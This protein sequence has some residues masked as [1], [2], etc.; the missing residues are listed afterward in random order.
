MRKR[1]GRVQQV[2]AM[3][4]LETPPLR[5]PSQVAKNLA[6]AHMCLLPPPPGRVQKPFITFHNHCDH[7]SST[8]T[9]H[10]SK[11][12]VREPHTAMSTAIHQEN[13]NPS[14]T[15]RCALTSGLGEVWLTRR[16]GLSSLSCCKQNER[17]SCC[18]RD[19][20][21][22]W[23]NGDSAKASCTGTVSY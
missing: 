7:E 18:P 3:P 23:S 14:A 21:K 22:L 8:P 12:T 11:K 20:T 6:K 13:R 9:R 2:R 1:A 15:D 10:D 19:D 5:N 17:A 16:P 4:T